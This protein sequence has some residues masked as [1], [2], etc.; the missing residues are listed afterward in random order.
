MLRKIL[1]NSALVGAI[2]MGSQLALADAQSTPTPESTPVAQN[3][4]ASAIGAAFDGKW[5]TTIAP[6]IWVPGISGTLVFRHPGLAGVGGAA[7]QESL[8]NVS[9]GPT[10]Y[11]AFINSGGLIAGELRKNAF[12]LAGDLMF[13]NLSHTGSSNVTITGPGGRVEIP[14]TASVGWHLNNTL[15]ELAPG[16]TVAHGSAGS[17]DAFAGVRSLSLRSD[18]SW[19]FTGPLT[20]VPLT[21]SASESVTVADFI[22]GIRGK[23]RLGERWF[24]PYY[25]DLGTGG[26]STTSQYYVGFGYASH[27]GNLL[28][29]YRSLGYNQTKEG[30][31]IK[32]LNLAGVALGAT[33][34]LK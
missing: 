10:N 22:G 23:V 12:S 17:I 21:G 14:V 7:T 26:D 19:T 25:G 9:T 8:I 30:A 13:L 5:H 24:L 1:T 27:W 11:L 33:F 3:T 2:A 29:V 20:L 28:L 32:N 31:R 34:E 4:P 6:Y 18:A 15:W 16:V